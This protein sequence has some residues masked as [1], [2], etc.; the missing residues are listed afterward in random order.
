MI[1]P[2]LVSR[3]YMSRWL[4][5][6]TLSW[7]FELGLLAAGLSWVWALSEAPKTLMGAGCSLITPLTTIDKGDESAA[8]AIGVRIIGNFRCR[9]WAAPIARAASASGKEG[10]RAVG[11]GALLGV[12]CPSPPVPGC[13]VLMP[14]RAAPSPT[15]GELSIAIFRPECL[16]NCN[17]CC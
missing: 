6:E 13:A 12:R 10:G 1:E 15:S 4:G 16:N 2:A 8:L 14:R 7:L 9:C 3:L 11:G 5:F 17:I